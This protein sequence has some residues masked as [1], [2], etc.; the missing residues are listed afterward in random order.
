MKQVVKWRYQKLNT[1]RISINFAGKQLE[2]DGIYEFIVESL[3]QTYCKPEWIGIE[4]VERYI[5]KNPEKMYR[6]T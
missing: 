5:M 6:V 3:E 1:G 2:K 4:V